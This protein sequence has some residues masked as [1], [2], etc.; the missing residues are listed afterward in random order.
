MHD[1]DPACRG[2]LRL[3]G[4]RAEV[5]VITREHDHRPVQAKRRGSHYGV[6][7]APVTGH[8]DNA[9][10]ERSQ[11]AAPLLNWYLN[12]LQPLVEPQPSQT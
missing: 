7:R 10:E 5:I 9:Q 8:A 6:N 1:G 3:L 2:L 11:L 12:Q 4:E